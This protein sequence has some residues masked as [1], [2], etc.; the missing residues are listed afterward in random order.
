MSQGIPTPLVRD[1][2][3]EGHDPAPDG[4][5]MVDPVPIVPDPNACG[6]DLRRADDVESTSSVYDP[7]K[8]E[9]AALDALDTSF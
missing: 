8:A 4:A 2:G 9:R 6:E 5:F 1:G 7:K 3:V